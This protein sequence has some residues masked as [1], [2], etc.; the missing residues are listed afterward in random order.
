MDEGLGPRGVETAASAYCCSFSACVAFVGQ[1]ARGR[2]IGVEDTAGCAERRAGE[3][4]GELA[5]DRTRVTMRRT[6]NSFCRDLDSE[7]DLVG[8]RRCGAR[9]APWCSRRRSESGSL[10]GLPVRCGQPGGCGRKGR[11]GQRCRRLAHRDRLAMGGRRRNRCGGRRRGRDEARG[12]ARRACIDG[13]AAEGRRER[14]EGCH[15]GGN[16]EPRA[17]TRTGARP[18]RPGLLDVCGGARGDGQGESRGEG[19]R[20]AHGVGDPERLP[21]GVDHLA[22]AAEAVLRLPGRSPGPPAIELGGADSVDLARD[23][24]RLE[25]DLREEVSKRGL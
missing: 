21:E 22:R 15:D 18:R 16:K 9:R 12:R 2:A 20:I 10:C 25:D 5:R 14:R 23:R 4:E 3:G 11:R 6:R 7:I 1:R 19:L 17:T 24:E 13:A 8:R